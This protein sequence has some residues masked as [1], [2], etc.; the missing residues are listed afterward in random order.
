MLKISWMVKLVVLRLWGHC[1]LISEENVAAPIK[2]L[3]IE[4]AASL[5][6]VV[7]EMMKESGGFG[8]R[9]MTQ[10]INIVKEG[11]IPDY[12]RNSIL[13]PVYK[14]KGDPPVCGTYRDIKLMEQP[15]KV[16]E[17]VLEKMIRCQ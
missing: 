12:L 16:L 9:W 11:C 1:C 15:M 2:G 17:I 10:L 5:A 14:G 8:T 3:K 6:G 7:S 4:K 13:V